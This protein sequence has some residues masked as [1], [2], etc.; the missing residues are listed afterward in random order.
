M[1]GVTLYGRHPMERQKIYFQGTNTVSVTRFWHLPC[2]YWACRNLL[3]IYTAKPEDSTPTWSQQSRK[4]LLLKKSVFHTF[5]NKG[6][7]YIMA[8]ISDYIFAEEKKKK[9]TQHPFIPSLMPTGGFFFFLKLF[10]KTV[11]MLRAHF[12]QMELFLLRKN[13][14]VGLC[15]DWL[16]RANQQVLK[17][18][19]SII[20]RVLRTLQMPKQWQQ[21]QQ[22]LLTLLYST[23]FSFYFFNI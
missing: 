5:F 3:C 23:I 21:F 7:W 16:V 2:T 14:T 18:T 12:L 1:T 17:K 8:A 20:T 9:Q 10:F 4:S 19:L 11:F 13:W 15:S 22:L 6:V